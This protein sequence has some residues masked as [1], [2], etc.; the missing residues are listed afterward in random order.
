MWLRLI[1]TMGLLSSMGICNAQLAL[2]KEDLSFSSSANASSTGAPTENSPSANASTAS[3]PSA[4]A[5]TANA[6]AANASAANASTAS[7]ATSS[8]ST[9]SAMTASTSTGS[10]STTA[11]PTVPAPATGASTDAVYQDLRTM[12]DHCNNMKSTALDLLNEGRNAPSRQKW[13]A[14]YVSSAKDDLTILKNS[15]KALLIPDALKASFGSG[16]SDVQGSIAKLDELIPRLDSEAKGLKTP[17]DDKYPPVF[18]KTSSEFSK[19]ADDLDKALISIFNA[20]D[21]SISKTGPSI[22]SSS[23]PNTDGSESDATLQGSA[24]M[25][26][27]QVGFKKVGE[28][29]TKISKACW[30]LFGELERW[31]LLY[32]KPPAGGIPDGFYGGGLSSSEILSEYKYLPQFTFTNAPYVMLYSYRLPPRQNMLAYHTG[33]IG[34]LLNLM[35]S[36]LNDVQVPAD[37]Q[38]ALAGPWDQTKKLFLDCRQNYLSL[39]NLVNNTTDDRL[40]KNI[41]EDQIT[42][43]QPLMAIY[44]DMAKM[45]DSLN[46]IKK[47]IQ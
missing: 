26:D 32:G 34:K 13:V 46:D 9:P 33:Q 17:T 3:A 11:S 21:A 36:E 10:A 30:G 25:V 40:S 35:E 14:F 27:E 43:G 20:L 12:W 5:S 45:R 8:A 44:G 23:V 15:A 47:M 39:L 42:F 18:W 1:L 37:R 2:G 22:S 28:A 41:R 6:S 16:W 24:R 19:C 38:M 4:N 7:A 31:N 29:S